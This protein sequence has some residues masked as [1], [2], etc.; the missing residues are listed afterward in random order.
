MEVGRE[1]G[2]KQQCGDYRQNA[3]CGTPNTAGRAL[4]NGIQ[5]DVD[6]PSPWGNAVAD[7]VK[8]F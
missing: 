2:E 8:V 5:H 3:R 7:E 6:R 1:Y 4:E